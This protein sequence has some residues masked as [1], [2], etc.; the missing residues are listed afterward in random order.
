MASKEKIKYELRMYFFLFMLY[1]L[2]GWIYETILFSVEEGYFINRGFNFGPYIPIYGFGA[3]IIM[4]VISK[5]IVESDE[6]NKFSMR[7]LK[8]FILI[9][10]LSTVAELIGSYIM[11]Y[12]LGIILWDYTDE[13]M[14]FQGRI[15]PKTSFIFA[16]GGTAAYYTIQ[17]LGK[18]II[19]KVSIKGQKIFASFLLIL[20]LIDFSASLVTTIWFSDSIKK[21]GIMERK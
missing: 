13:W 4:I 1:S 18:K 7:P 21:A 14:N 10:V 9:L 12:S 11:E 15:S 8:I 16:A 5:F 3:V 20:I 17:P 19:D 6:N 2:I